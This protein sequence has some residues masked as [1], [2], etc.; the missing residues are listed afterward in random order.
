VAAG[1]ELTITVVPSQPGLRAVFTL[2]PGLVPSRSNL[3]G[4]VVRG[5]W[6]AVYLGV[7]SEGTTLRASFKAGFEEKA[8]AA[9]ATVMSSRFPGGSGWQSLPAWL[10]QENAVWEMDVAWI[11][12]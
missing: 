1:T 4:I 6:R 7:P 11:L 8:A 2:P 3:P 5:Q 10:P 9:K 12:R